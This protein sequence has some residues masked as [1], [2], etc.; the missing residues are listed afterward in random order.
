[1]E[2]IDLNNEFDYIV[3][4]SY[5][6]SEDESLIITANPPSIKE[7]WGKN[8]YLEYK[9]NLKKNHL[10]KQKDRCAYCRN[11]VEPDGN[12]EPIEHIV[13]KSIKPNWM[14]NPKNLV[15]TCDPCNNL[16]NDE[17]TLTERFMFSDIFPNVSEA[18]I[19]FNPHFDRW[20]DHFYIEDEIFLTAR[21]DSK[22]TDTIKICKL[23]RYQIPINN[24]RMLRQS[25]SDSYKT[26]IH[27][28]HKV[29]DKSSQQYKML[30]ELVDYFEPRVI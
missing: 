24:A 6:S 4:E 14:L 3:S 2:S 7:D 1:M 23:Y 12:Y 13:A 17:P 21:P 27:K 9:K 16:K 11:Y 5:I 30:L 18:F 19:I 28:M 26:I 20:R 29:A 25:D 22:G 10:L 8:V 15:V